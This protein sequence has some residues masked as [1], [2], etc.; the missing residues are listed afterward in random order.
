MAMRLRLEIV[1]EGETKQTWK[2]FKDISKILAKYEKKCFNFRI[3]VLAADWGRCKCGRTKVQHSSTAIRRKSGLYRELSAGSTP[4]VKSVVPLEAPVV[5]P[6]AAADVADDEDEDGEEGAD[7]FPESG[8]AAASISSSEEFRID[9]S[10]GF[11]Y[12]MQDFISEYGGTDEWEM[13][14]PAMNTSRKMTRALL[15]MPDFSVSSAEDE[16]FRIDPND[17]NAY[18][19]ASFLSEYGGTAEWDAAKPPTKTTR[20]MS[21]V[22]W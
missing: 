21:K 9:P 17:G 2:E 7:S 14:E 10:D 4:M 1:V 3:D 8:P 22:T 5:E 13:A 12:S 19:K 6:A 11:A 16:E 20:R 15:P 18:Q